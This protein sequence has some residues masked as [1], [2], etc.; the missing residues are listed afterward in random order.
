MIIWFN[1]TANHDNVASQLTHYKTNSFAIQNQVSH[2]S[3]NPMSPEGRAAGVPNLPLN[4][5][6]G[7]QLLGTILVS[8]EFWT[9]RLNR[10]SP[11]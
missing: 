5:D 6:F 4:P 1:G 11:I 10:K 7:S 8:L 9:L 3:C 2:L